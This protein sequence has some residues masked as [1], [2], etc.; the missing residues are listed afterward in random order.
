[1]NNESDSLMVSCY[2]DSKRPLAWLSR[3]VQLEADSASVL[4]VTQT[5]LVL[6]FEGRVAHG[7]VRPRLGLT[8]DT[9]VL[10]LVHSLESSCLLLGWVLERMVSQT[11]EGAGF[12]F[13]ADVDPILVSNQMLKM[14]NLQKQETNG[15]RLCL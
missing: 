8:D 13:V 15:Y 11:L 12:W 1:M 10:E 4:V 7:A 3:A 9:L 5:W 6:V 2:N 14:E